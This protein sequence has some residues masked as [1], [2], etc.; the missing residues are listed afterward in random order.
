VLY[1]SLR[2]GT[3]RRYDLRAPEGRNSWA[4]DSTARGYVASVRGVALGSDGSRVDLPAPR[5]FRRVLYRAELVRDRGGEPLAE[6]VSAVCD[7][8][9]VSLTMHLNGRSRRFRFDVDRRG[10]ARFL[11]AHSGGTGGTAGG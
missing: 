10:T 4:V 11:P 3:V 1:V 2:D 5:R 9:V 6:R 7:D 8:V